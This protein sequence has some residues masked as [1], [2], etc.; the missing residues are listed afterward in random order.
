MIVK[1]HV[2]TYCDSCTSSCMSSCSQMYALILLFAL[3]LFNVTI[4]LPQLTALLCLTSIVWNF[5]CCSVCMSFSDFYFTPQYHHYH[6]TYSSLHVY[7]M[8]ASTD[9]TW[10]PQQISVHVCMLFNVCRLHILL[11]GSGYLYVCVCVNSAYHTHTHMHTRTRTH[12]QMYYTRTRTHN[13]HTHT[14]NIHI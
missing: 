9:H 10:P 1:T 3:F 2:T 6:T 8:C 14:H 7:V 13:T 4:L 12:T 11:H 5:G